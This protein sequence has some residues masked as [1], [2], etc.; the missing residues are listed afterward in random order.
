MGEVVVR[1]KSELKEAIEAKID[2]IFVEG[3][4]VGQLKKSKR[5][6]TLGVAGLAAIAALA[7]ASPFTMGV[8]GIVAAG[9][10]G[11]ELSALV[12]VVAVGVAVL[13]ALFK[14]YEEI[15]ISMTS[16]KFK[17]KSSS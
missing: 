16:A 5:I 14:D 8:S 6:A 2:V 11:M 9:I 12:F 15:E 7:A 13:L 4:L 17:R 3:E 1:T 10:T